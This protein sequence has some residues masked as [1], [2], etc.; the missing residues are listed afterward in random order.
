MS[1]AIRLYRRVVRTARALD[2]EQRLSAMG[3]ARTAFARGATLRGQALD[4]AL[5]LGEKRVEVARH[6]GIAYE[7]MSHTKLAGGGNKDIEAPV[8]DAT[9]SPTGVSDVL[10]STMSAQF[11]VN[12][13]GLAARAKARAKRAAVANAEM[14]GSVD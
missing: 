13:A 6:Y 3:E 9:G 2:A 5:E 4:D 14:R 11:P 1:R 8:V 10:R 12:P 7:R